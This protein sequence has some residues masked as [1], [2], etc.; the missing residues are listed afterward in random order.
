MNS[1]SWLVMTSAPLYSL[2]Q[3]SSQT[4]VSTSRWFVGSSMSSALGS[5][6]SILAR[7]MRI[8]HP[9]EKLSAGSPQRSAPMPRPDR[10]SSARCSSPY[11]FR[12]RNSVC[13]RPYRSISAP[14]NGAAA[15]SD[16][17]CSRS[18]SSSPISNTLPAPESV[19]SMALPPRISPT[20]CE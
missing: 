13:R 15:A 5:R 7:A 8:F 19:S 18:R 1:L 9:P 2:S 11:P 3:P 14:L 6:S 20:S 17:L 12:C 4:I 10:I 16:I